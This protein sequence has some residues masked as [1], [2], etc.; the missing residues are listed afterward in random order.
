VRLLHS[1]AKTHASF[2]DP[3]LV[4]HAGLVP[5][6]ALARRAGLAGLVAEHV[7]PGGECGVNAP[8]KVACLV[9]GMAAGADSIDDMDLLRHGAMS[10][11]FGGIRAPSTLGSHLRSYAWGNVSQLDKAG[12]EFLIALAGRAPL[13]PGAGTLAFIDVDSM[14]KRVY[15]HHKQGARFGHTKIQGRSLL[16]RG[17]NA[18]AAVVS[19]PLSAPV[20]AATRLRGGNAASARG[21]ASLAARA[22]G[23]ARDCG[24]TGMIIVRLDSAFYNA[25]VI[26]AIRRGGARFSVTAPMNAS[27]RAAIAAIPE[28]AWTAIKYPHA[29]WDDQL[30]CWV[31]DAEVAETRYTAF[32]SKKGQAVTARLVVRRVRDLNKQAAAG[33]D[34]LF[35]LWRHHAV[36]TDSPFEL[37]QAEGQHRDHAIIEQ[38]FADVTSGPLAHMPSG[39]FTANAAWLSIAAMAHNLLRAAGALASLPFAKARA[40]TIRRDLIAVAARTARHGRGHLTLHLPDGWHREHEWQNLFAAA[41]GPPAAPA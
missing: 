9:A 2:D 28:Q 19:T 23:T 35:P 14:Q 24:C 33:Q 1:L 11:L 41:C 36:F 39:V 21:A 6:M 29:I 4:S 27:I 12:R 17:L 10:T 40:A 5:V 26:G 20:I 13:L 22:I 38:V 15:G 31:S 25:A 3:N 18:L 30:R 16:V 37:I 32:A 7:R 8:L 34:E